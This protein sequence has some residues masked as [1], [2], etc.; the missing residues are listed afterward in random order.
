MKKLTDEELVEFLK[1][2]GYQKKVVCSSGLQVTVFSTSEE[3][4]T[5]LTGDVV[6]AIVLQDLVKQKLDEAKTPVSQKMKD[7][8]ALLID[9]ENCFEL[10]LFS[11]RNIADWLPQ[12]VAGLFE[13]YPELL[14]IALELVAKDGYI[15]CDRTKRAAEGGEASA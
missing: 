5:Y 15:G 13:K 3:P 12:R 8:V 4:E 14:N 1:L 6:F 2:Y 10:K 7:I 11:Y 9:I